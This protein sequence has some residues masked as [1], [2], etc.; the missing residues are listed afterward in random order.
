[1]STLSLIIL[2]SLAEI[3]IAFIG[4][5]LTLSR[6]EWII[7]KMHYLLSLAAGTFLGV[8]FLDLIPEAFEA[9]EN[10]PMWML[11]GFILFLVLSRGLFW[12]H[13]HH[14]DQE[15]DMEN[16]PAP[17]GPLVIIGDSIH[18]FVDG[19]L[20]AFSFLASPALGVATTVAVLVH[21][22]PQELADFFVLLSAGYSKKKAIMLNIL[23]SIPT[24]IGAIIAYLLGSSIEWIIGPMLAITAGNFLYLAA[25]DIL[26]EI[27]KREEGSGMRIAKQIIILIIGIAII[28]VTLNIFPHAHG[29]SDDHTDEEVHLVANF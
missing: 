16:H 13:H 18:N 9:T 17:R 7:S 27:T 4:I 11:F 20:I 1:M 19:T 10:A 8:V 12:Y 2:A 26:P 15:S 14:H 3:L 21:E 22:F 25:S 29:E 6:R 28:W 24:L 5:L 23:S